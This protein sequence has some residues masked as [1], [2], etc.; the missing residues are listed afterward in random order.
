MVPQKGYLGRTNPKLTVSPF[1]GVARPRHSHQAPRRAEKLSTVKDRKDTKKT[2]HH[3][4]RIS[5]EA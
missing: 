5:V 4:T 3:N 1:F 2:T